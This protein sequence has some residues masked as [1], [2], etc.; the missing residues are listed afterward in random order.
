MDKGFFFSVTCSV[1]YIEYL[2]PTFCMNTVIELFFYRVG[3]H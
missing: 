3:I 1:N 2:L